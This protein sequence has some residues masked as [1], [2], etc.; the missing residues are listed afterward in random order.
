MNKVDSNCPRVVAVVQ[1]KAP[2][3]PNASSDKE[4]SNL[5]ISR[6]VQHSYVPSYDWKESNVQTE[7]APLSLLYK[8]GI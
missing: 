3:I 5:F 4:P 7:I 2:T 6:R 1:A 8:L